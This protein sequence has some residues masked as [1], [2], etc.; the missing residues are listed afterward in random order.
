MKGGLFTDLRTAFFA[1]GD[2]PILAKAATKLVN[3]G[4]TPAVLSEAAATLGEELEPQ[5][6]Q[7]ASASM[8]RYLAKILLA[9]CASALL[10]RP[11][12]TGGGPV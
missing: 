4:I 2:R 7:Q 9:R 12:L 8:R 3:V 1:V 6:D 10:G 5:E 11:D